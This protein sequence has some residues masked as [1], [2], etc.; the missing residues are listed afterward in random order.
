MPHNALSSA[1][2]TAGFLPA[3]NRLQGLHIFEFGARTE[4]IAALRSKVQDSRVIANGRGFA[5]GHSLG[6]LQL[7]G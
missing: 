3:Q 5:F 1:T 7:S 2:V 4:C 6:K